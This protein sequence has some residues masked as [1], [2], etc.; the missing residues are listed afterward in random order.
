MLVFKEII[1]YIF[2]I[3]V[4]QAIFL[5]FILWRKK[6]NSFANKFLAVT[7]LIFAIDLLAGISYLTGYVNQIPWVVGLNNTLPYLY[8]PL[9]YLYVIFLIHER[10]FFTKYD[11][12]H[13]I[14]FLIVTLYGLFFFYFEGKEYQLSLL[15]LNKPQ[16]WH[17]QLVGKLIPVSGIL[18]VFFTIKTTIR[19]NRYIKNSFANVEN[20]DLNWLI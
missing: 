5:F 12:L 7:M 2:A 19:Y 3:G 9:I 14:P 1:T 11:Y 16:P 18:Y 10:E 4:A 20:I 17:I 8:G 15:D 13:F 6:E